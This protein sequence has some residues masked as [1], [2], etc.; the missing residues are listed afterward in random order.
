MTNSH[1]VPSTELTSQP[2]RAWRR[3]VASTFLALTFS[4]FMSAE[5]LAAGWT[6]SA[7]VQYLQTGESGNTYVSVIGDEN[8][9]TCLKG[10]WY[11]ISDSGAT[12]RQVVATLMAARAMGAS[13][14]IYSKECTSAGYNAL[15]MVR[16]QP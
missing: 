9:N 14:R 2:P 5:A 12:T 11:L 3:V 4:T 10:G 6:T 13:V 16:I 15:N 8:V 7:T 1:K